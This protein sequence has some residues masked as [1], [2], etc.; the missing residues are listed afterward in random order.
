MTPPRD[1]EVAPACRRPRKDGGAGSVEYVGIALVVVVI[2]GGLVAVAGN[3]GGS[4]MAQIEQAFCSVGD[5]SGCGS[6]PQP[7]SAPQDPGGD[8]ADQDPVPTDTGT[9]DTDGEDASDDDRRDT[10]RDARDSRRDDRGRDEPEEGPEP[11]V[12]GNEDYTNLGDPVD[13]ESVPTPE[14][15]PWSPADGGAGPYDSEDA[16]AGD[17]ATKFAA[18]AAA[19]AMSGMWPNASRN[20]LHFLGN[21]GGPLEQDV[22][23]MLADV[24]ALADTTNV[25]VDNL[26]ATAVARAR[27]TG[28]DGPVTFPVSTPWQGFYITKDLSDDWFY[29]LGGVSFS[30]VGEVTVYPPTTAGGEW[31][32]EATTSVVVRDQYNWDGGKSTQIGP[33]EVTDEQLAEL[34]R[35]GLAQEFA[36]VGQSAATSRKGTA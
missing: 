11:A 34:H 13:G 32:Y 6:G 7:V 1:T 22:D 16:G 17:H 2:I 31:T 25:T 19:N 9:D 8:P 21:S 33:F 18:E 10:A 28:A 36:A 5:A 4:V 20:L 12:P 27:E 24:P 26:A 29:A 35:K 30:V 23:G 15:P 3:A 14:P